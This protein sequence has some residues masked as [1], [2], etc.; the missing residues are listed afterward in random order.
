MKKLDYKS[1]KIREERFLIRRNS[2]REKAIKDLCEFEENNDQAHASQILKFLSPIERFGSESTSEELSLKDVSNFSFTTKAR[3]VFPVKRTILKQTIKPLRIENVERPAEKI[4][5][6]FKLSQFASYKNLKLNNDV[7]MKTCKGEGI[8]ILQKNLST[9]R[10]I[11]KSN[12]DCQLSN[13]RSN[14]FYLSREKIFNKFN[15]FKYNANL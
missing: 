3:S 1:L 15:R 9:E 2:S 13:K 10:D 8:K 14:D 4:E 7:K 12:K 5:E 6:V 11:S